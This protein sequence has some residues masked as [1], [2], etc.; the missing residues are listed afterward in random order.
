MKKRTTKKTAIKT[1]TK[2]AKPR[3]RKPTNRQATL[4]ARVKPVNQK[5]FANLCKKAKLST[6]EGMDIAL[7]FL[8]KDKFQFNSTID[9]STL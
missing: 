8:K 4:Y 7:T 5:W 6:G 3:G 9:T 1:T 2:T